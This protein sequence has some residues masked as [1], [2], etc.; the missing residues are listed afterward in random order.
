MEFA[1]R[2]TDIDD[3]FGKMVTNYMYNQNDIPAATLGIRCM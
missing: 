1:S 2:D 3:T